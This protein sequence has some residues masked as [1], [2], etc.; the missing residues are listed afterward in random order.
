MSRRARRFL[1]FAAVAL[2]VAAL[3]ALAQSRFPPEPGP[4][5]AQRALLAPDPR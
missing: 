1:T 3:I 5:G 4:G 2:T